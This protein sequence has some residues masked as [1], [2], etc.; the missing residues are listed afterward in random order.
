MSFA[1]AIKRRKCFQLIKSVLS[2][3]LLLFYISGTFGSEVLHEFIH[4]HQVVS[5]SEQAEKNPCHRQLY[6]QDERHGCSHLSHFLQTDKCK[7]CDHISKVD[8]AI[9]FDIQHSSLTFE[10]GDPACDFPATSILS[11]TSRSSRAPPVI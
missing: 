10:V 9:L 3:G 6:H 7:L 11:L 5:H 1:L 4:R 2:L 8:H